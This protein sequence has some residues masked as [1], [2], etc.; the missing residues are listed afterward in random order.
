MQR[1]VEIKLQKQLGFG[2]GTTYRFGIQHSK[3]LESWHP[4]IRLFGGMDLFGR[5]GT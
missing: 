2:A 3:E 1:M 5:S 4:D